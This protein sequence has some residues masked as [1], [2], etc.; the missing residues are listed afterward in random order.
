MRI[1]KYLHSCLLV[2]DRDKRLLIDPG[3]FTFVEESVRIDDI[4]PIDA[5]LITHTHAD[6]VHP[7]TVRRIKE[8]DDA[9][10][11][12]NTDVARLLG[13]M[14]IAV[15]PVAGCDVSVAGF[16]VC[17]ISA[18]HEKTLSSTVP[19]NTAYCINDRLLIP[20]DSLSSALFVHKGV[21]I[22]ALPVVAPWS[23][24]P[25]SAKFA[26][27]LAPQHVIPVHDGYIKPFF[28]AMMYERYRSVLEK[29]GVVFHSLE[30]LGQ[31]STF[32]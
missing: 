8:R 14:G 7:E 15:T 27:A 29:R 11:V 31:S 12:G 22:L 25:S 21:E 30:K 10:I 9:E 6:H 23:S 32:E 16:R 4:P 26:L 20:G 18:E 2:E 19:E 28:Q 17:P 13:T 24:E 1:V 5:M 3:A